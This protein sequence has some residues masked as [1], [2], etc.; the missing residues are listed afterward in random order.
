M[1]TSQRARLEGAGWAI[2]DVAEFLDLSPDEAKYVEL[3]LALVAGV[4]R[5]REKQGLTQSALAKKTGFQPVARGQDGGGDR[6]VTL[7]LMMRSLLAI[8][9]TTG[10]IAELIKRADRRRA[11]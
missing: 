6:S 1:N 11:A 10:E 5:S 4:R 3:K 2:G 8:G 9:A 7:D